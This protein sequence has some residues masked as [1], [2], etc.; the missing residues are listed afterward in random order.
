M[1]MSWYTVSIQTRGERVGMVV[2][3][4]ENSVTVTPDLLS[5]KHSCQDDMIKDEIL[6]LPNIH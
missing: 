1:Y 4:T 2:T 6:I 3:E 5:M